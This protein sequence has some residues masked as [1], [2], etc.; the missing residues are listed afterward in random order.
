MKILHSAAVCEL[1]FNGIKGFIEESS[2]MIGISKQTSSWNSSL[3]LL[4]AARRWRKT[5]SSRMLG[6]WIT[7]LGY[8]TSAMRCCSSYPLNLVQHE[9]KAHNKQCEGSRDC[10]RHLMMNF[11]SQH[12]NSSTSARWEKLFPQ[13]KSHCLQAHPFSSSRNVFV[14]IQLTTQWSSASG[15]FNW[16]YMKDKP[17]WLQWSVNRFIT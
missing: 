10:F 16:N 9:S 1:Q 12:E 8:L 17:C 15:S 11:G 7:S 13:N 3:W 2:D 6:M 4:L 5:L 14:R